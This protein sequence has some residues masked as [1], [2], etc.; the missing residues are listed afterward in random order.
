MGGPGAPDDLVAGYQ[1]QVRLA[2]HHAI[3]PP[4]GGYWHHQQTRTPHPAAH[5]G[6]FQA[7]LLEALESRT[8]IALG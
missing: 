4:T 5:D 6:K 8:G 7:Q 2:T 3:A 1:T